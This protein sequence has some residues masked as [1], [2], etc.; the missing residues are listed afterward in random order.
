M[1]VFFT[2]PQ[3]GEDYLKEDTTVVVIDVLRATTTICHAL[4][5]GCH[6]LIP[7]SDLGEATGFVESLGRD[8]CLLGG[9]RNGQKISGFDFGNSPAEYTA[10]KVRHQNIVFLTTNGSR[11]ISRFR[12]AS[13]VLI[14]SFANMSRVV[15][16][17]KE[18]GGQ[19]AICCAGQRDQFCLEDSVCA[20]MIVQ[21]LV[22]HFPEARLNDAARVGQVLAAS[23]AD[24]LKACFEEASHGRH[25]QSI[26]FESDLAL[27]AQIDSLEV[28]PF[29]ANERITL[30]PEPSPLR[31][32]RPVDV[33]GPALS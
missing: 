4:A 12:S 7:V 6:S 14:A 30:A 22:E 15:N 8:N 13:R 24:N 20:G 32:S 5:H 3:V 27:C 21:R 26:G 28:L 9:E 10:A 33:D 16:F 31:E 18:T 23:Y 11:I 17:L 2:L 19:V 29:Y 1:D 25:L